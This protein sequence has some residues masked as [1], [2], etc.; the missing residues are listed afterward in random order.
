M[1]KKI[2][3]FNSNCGKI[4]IFT[5]KGAKSFIDKSIKSNILNKEI[6]IN[7]YTLVED[8]LKKV[9]TGI[10][11]VLIREEISSIGEVFKVEVFIEEKTF[12][13]GIDFKNI[14]DLLSKRALLKAS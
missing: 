3:E 9:Y 7:H 11:N 8:R 13:S 6:F 12:F 4:E 14:C 1:V 10:H 2:L 5:F